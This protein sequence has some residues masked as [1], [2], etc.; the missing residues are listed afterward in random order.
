MNSTPNSER[1]HIGIFGNRNVGKS[2][3]I[4]AITSQDLAIVS[5]V[6]GTTTDP[7]KKAMELLPLGPVV[8]VDTPGLDDIGELGEKRVKKAFEVLR[9]S[10]IILLVL[11]YIDSKENILNYMSK[12]LIEN[13]KSNMIPFL[14][15][16]NKID[17]KNDKLE[18]DFLR[19]EVEDF[20]E[21]SSEKIQEVSTVTKEGI[22]ELKEK[23]GTQKTEKKNLIVSD[24]I[25]EN[26]NV[27]LV[28][29][30]DESAPKGRII[31]PQQQVIR[32]VLD[33]NA[34]V[35][36]S[37]E[38]NYKDLLD[39]VENIS[40]VICDSQVFKKIDEITPDDINLTSFSILMARYKG[41]LKWQCEGVK[42]F[43]SLENGDEILIA[44][45]CTH[46]RQ[47]GDIGTVKL[48]NL[49]ERKTRKKLQYKFVSGT[50]FPSDLS[51]YKMVI[52]C[53]GC[54]LNEKE[55]KSRILIA[56]NANVPITNYGIAIAYLNGILER[57]LKVFDFC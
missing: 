52:H 33:S 44:E 24:L 41:D 55:M 54:T 37:K 18:L 31:L 39:S 29:P 46:H 3:L 51:K 30:I 4:N 15:I 6:K 32:D 2:S 20:F 16:I 25:R 40:L 42:A 10:D 13:A 26:D 11:D 56:K 47:C 21:V 19:K 28:I 23:I 22:N 45:G 9:Y 17:E 5:S 48:P 27:I 8:F 38:N 50:E 53:G 1:I 57:S 34:F 35:H 12:K 36:I 49:I 43:D 14:I 7:V